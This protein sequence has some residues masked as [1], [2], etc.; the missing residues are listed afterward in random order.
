MRHIA[1]VGPVVIAA[2]M[3]CTV[4]PSAALATQPEFLP[5]NVK[6]TT[7]SGT[8]TFWRGST[9][10]LT[11]SKDTGKGVIANAITADLIWTLEG[12]TS[13]LGKCPTINL[14][15]IGELGEVPKAQAASE[16][17][18]LF[19]ADSVVKCGTVEAVISGN[20]AGEV[21]PVGTLTSTGEVAFDVVGAA[22]EQKIKEITING[23]HLNTLMLVS[24]N[25]GPKERLT[26]ES[27]ESNS[28]S[29]NV[30]VML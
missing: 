3:L 30:E 1:I 28:F 15:Q 12:C 21:T 29:S 8:T 23:K 14:E 20:V 2:L 19:N 25:S 4:A 7:S 17:G 27:T 5:T 6:F 13:P 24:I 26:L 18:Q 22:H 16:V 10:L 11:C 9:A